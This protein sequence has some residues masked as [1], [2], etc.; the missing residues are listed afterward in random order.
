MSENTYTVTGMTCDHCVRAVTDEVGKI[1]GV[2]KVAVD[3]PNGK[4]TV[5]S[6]TELGDA[7]VRAA[8]EE[9]GY[10]LAA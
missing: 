4:V 2:Q 1:D 6:T 5:S 8:V 9:A 10:E 7:D 3:L